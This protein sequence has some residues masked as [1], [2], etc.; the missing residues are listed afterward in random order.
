[1][2]N[3]TRLPHNVI[4]SSLS[5]PSCTLQQV[6]KSFL[7]KA[8][9]SFCSLE[10]K[11]YFWGGE[12]SLQ[13]KKMSVSSSVGKATN[14]WAGLFSSGLNYIMLFHCPECSTQ[15]DPSVK[16]PFFFALPSKGMN[17]LFN[18][19]F[20]TVNDDPTMQNKTDF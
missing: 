1:M 3:S 11:K 9:I 10:G 15:Y 17:L 7:T 8:A 12:C 20:I 4:P 19:V 2:R 13:P 6:H 5:Q 18:S 16:V 14:S